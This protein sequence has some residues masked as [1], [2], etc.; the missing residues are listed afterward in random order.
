MTPAPAVRSI[1]LSVFAAVLLAANAGAATFTVT[2]TNDSGA[3][4]LRQAILDADAA[5]GS[6]TIAFSIGSGP[7]AITPLTTLPFI[8]NLHG[9]I[10]I[11]GST[12]PGFAGKPLI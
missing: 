6:I 10:V 11:D 2:N 8:G 4:S 5:T 1:L 7:Q 3:G 9:T 12:Q